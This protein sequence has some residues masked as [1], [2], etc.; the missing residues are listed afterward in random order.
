MRAYAT[1]D[2]RKGTHVAGNGGDHPY[3]EIPYG[4]GPGPRRPIPEV[5]QHYAQVPPPPQRQGMLAGSIS[6][7]LSCAKRRRFGSLRSL[8]QLPKDANLIWLVSPDSGRQSCEVCPPRSRDNICT[9]SL[10]CVSLTSDILCSRWFD[11]RAGGGHFSLCH[12]P[13]SGNERGGDFQLQKNWLIKS[14][15]KV[16]NEAK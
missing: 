8:V 14:A 3:Q 15:C 12:F 10:H 7:L 2:P 11:A 1:Y 6:P 9:T 13:P 5:P 4:D 16:C